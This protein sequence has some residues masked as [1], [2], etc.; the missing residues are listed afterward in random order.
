[1]EASGRKAA[2][3]PRSR[4]GSVDDQSEDSFPASDA[5]SFAPGAIGAPANRRTRPKTSRSA[6][7]RAAERKLKAAK[8]RKRK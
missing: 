7:V 1:M 4:P 8:S 2:Y 3:P 6:D 5:P